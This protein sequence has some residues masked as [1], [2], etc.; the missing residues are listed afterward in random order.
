VLPEDVITWPNAGGREMTV[1]MTD[2]LLAIARNEVGRAATEFRP[3][4]GRNEVGFTA[5][6]AYNDYMAS[7]AVIHLRERG[8][9]VPED[10]SVVGFDNAARP[11]WY[12][13][14][15]LTTVAMPL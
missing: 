1:R 6:M 7:A 3:D 15:P 14:P 13:G 8:V 2:Q 12:D 5:L 11:D 9:R 4:K 10:V